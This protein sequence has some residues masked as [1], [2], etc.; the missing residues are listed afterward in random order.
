MSKKKRKN[1]NYKNSPSATKQ[2]NTK[3]SDGKRTAI[4]VSVI[5]LVAII[6]STVVALNSC[7]RDYTVEISVK[8]YGK[9]TLELDGDA[10]PKTVKNFVSLVSDGFY[11]GLTF[12]RIMPNFMIQ[13]GDPQANG[14]GGS[15]KKIYGEFASNGWDNPISHVRGVISMA[16]GDDPDSASSQFFICNADSTFL[17]GKYAAF[18]RVVSG[19]EVVD[20]IT[21]D[22]AIFN[23]VINDKSIQPVIEYIKVID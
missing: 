4:I 14:F 1:N 15:S 8:N 2:S 7:T 9:I 17:D 3:S 22:Y 5:A 11:D 20:A 23:G 13:G 19:M 16:R 21:E 12:H 6:I 10:A 18:G